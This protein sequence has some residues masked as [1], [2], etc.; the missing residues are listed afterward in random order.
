MEEGD[1]RF[2]KNLRIRKQLTIIFECVTELGLWDYLSEH[3]VQRYV[4]DSTIDKISWECE[5]N[6][7][8]FTENEWY[9]CLATMCE[10]AQYGWEEYLIK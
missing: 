8:E 9:N 3:T 10:I 7:T 1:F 2:I 6:D 4:S 5:K